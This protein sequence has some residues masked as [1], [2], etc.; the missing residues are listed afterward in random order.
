MTYVLAFDLGA[1]S[2]R[3]VLGQLVDGKIELEELHRFSNDPVQVGGELHWDIL[4]LL[5][6][7][8]QA[9]IKAK[10]RGIV[11]DS[12]GID[13]WGVD[14]GTLNEQGK[15]LGNPYHYRD[16]HTVGVMEQLIEK[17]SA[18]TIFGRTGIQMMGINTLY[19]LASLKTNQS[20]LLQGAKH[21]LMTPALLRYFLTNEMH[22][23]FSMA[24][25]S[26]LFNPIVGDWDDHLLEAIDIEKEMLGN[27]VQPGTYVGQLS[28]EVCEELTI[29]PIPVIAV[30][31]HDTGSAVVAVPA[32]EKSFA[33]LSSGT[34]SL[35]GTEVQTP[36]INE[37]S[38][39]LNFTNE[40]GAYGTYRLLKNIMG[41]W[42]IQ[43]S[44]RAWEKAGQTYSFPELVKLA[45]QAEPFAR[46][47]DVDDELFMHPGNMPAQINVYLQQ[48]NQQT[49]DDVGSIARVIMESLAFKYRIALEQIEQ[50][51]GEVY[52][53]LH[54][55]GGGIQNTL[56]CQWT[57]NA[58][59]KP[60]KAGPV[61]GSAIG[62]MVVQ[63]ISAGKLKDVWEAREVIKRSFPIDIYESKQTEEWNTAFE[64]YKLITGQ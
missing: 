2:G 38:Q 54:I 17:L 57:A 52:D 63:W 42:I 11:L 31:E 28:A 8:K 27:V 51:T 12:M 7:L 34:W 58:I 23:E 46:F 59:G 30:A 32:E 24:T 41:L 37:L 5:H 16:T 14:F 56:L 25:T 64:Q 26:Q 18:E 4:R 35:I 10:N 15:L 40:G 19:Q 48:T 55:V 61:E 47:I 22:N 3:A 13:S 44:R 9:L 20:H 36:V 43:E 62:N 21:I 39:Q 33:Y 50:L 45:E 29:D 49:T 1:S 6:E 60:I 53:G